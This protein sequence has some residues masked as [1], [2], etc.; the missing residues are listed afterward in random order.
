MAV[1][2]KGD[3]KFRTDFRLY[4]QQLQHMGVGGSLVGALLREAPLH[5][6]TVHPV[7]V[8]GIGVTNLH[9]GFVEGDVRRHA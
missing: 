3:G 4:A 1:H 9:M 6:V 8:I 7:G 2:R 5:R